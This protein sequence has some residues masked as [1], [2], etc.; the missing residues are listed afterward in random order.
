MQKS[1]AEEHPEL[2]HYTNA[3]GLTG[4][5]RNQTLWATHHAYLND[6]EE[7]RYFGK[8]RL[9]NLLQ[10]VG[11]TYLNGLIAK[12]QKKQ[13]SIDKCGGKREIIDRFVKETLI[14]QENILFGNQNGKKPLTEPYITSFCTTK[15]EDNRV[16]DHGLL[17]Q[18]RGYGQEGGYAIVFDT[19]RLS[20]LLEQ[21][22]IKRENSWDLFLGDV[23][24]SSD[25]DTKFLLEFETDLREI[26]NFFLN[27]LKK[28]DDS[29][30]LG[31]FY[32][33]LM[34]CACRYKHWGF[35]EENEVRI[36]AIPHPT[37][38]KE[39]CN[40]AKTNGVIFQELPRKHYLRSNTLIPYID[41]FEDI[42]STKNPLPINR[43]IVGPSANEQER[44]KRIRAVEILLNQYGIK[45]G[46]SA[47]EI[48]YIG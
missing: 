4:I 39:F 43:I 40:H 5:I 35:K 34:K 8:D 37:E 30:N 31:K 15:D 6:S 27:H 25:P 42:T 48:P 29:E 32:I 14:A 20:N 9:P 23:V 28:I 16:K 7:I 1:V 18:W 2:F 11:E 22:D 38:N 33:A 41:L 26:E 13:L 24:Y 21:V 10:T 45:A 12:D 19:I 47:S 36:I 46:V 44:R 17:S 3:A